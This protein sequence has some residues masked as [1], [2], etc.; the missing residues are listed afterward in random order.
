[1]VEYVLRGFGI[2]RNVEVPSGAIYEPSGA[3]LGMLKCARFHPG[4]ERE[5]RGRQSTLL[6]G[7]R[8]GRVPPC[9]CPGG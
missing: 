6:F 4:S 9:P 5:R 2:V 3:I 1:M 8:A 7:K